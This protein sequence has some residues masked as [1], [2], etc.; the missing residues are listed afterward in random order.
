[1]CEN[2]GNSVWQVLPKKDGCGFVCP[3]S[4]A[5]ADSASS[6]TIENTEDQIEKFLI[7]FYKIFRKDPGLVETPPEDM[8]K[9]VASMLM[10]VAK[11]KYVL[12]DPPAL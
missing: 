4:Q 3:S 12:S 2:H 9:L 7:G 1:M 10:I 5:T 11:T 6:K 8:G